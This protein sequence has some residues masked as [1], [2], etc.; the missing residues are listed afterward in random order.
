MRINV[1]LFALVLL[2]AGLGASAAAPARAQE[3]ARPGKDAAQEVLQLERAWLDAYERYDAKAMDEI[4]ADDFQITFPDGSTQGKA[5]VMEMVRRAPGAGAPTVKF[6]TEN[7]RARVFGADTVVLSGRVVS[8]YT[9]GAETMRQEQ[10]YTDTYVRL[11]G[12]WQVVAS[13]LSSAPAPK[14]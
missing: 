9:R 3:S 14:R 5:Q 4:V 11:K 8:E 10:F 2:A 13:H 7:V 1:R 12:R 6:R